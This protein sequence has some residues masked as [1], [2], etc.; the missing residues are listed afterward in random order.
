MVQNAKRLLYIISETILSIS[1]TR[2]LM[3]L[4]LLFLSMSTV[5]FALI[6]LGPGPLRIM[7]GKGAIRAI[8]KAMRHAIRPSLD[9]VERISRGQA[10]KK[11]GVGSR[12][13]PH[14]LNQAERKEWDLAKQR[15]YLMLRGTGWRKERK[16]SP[17]ANIYRNYCDAVGIPS[18]N[19]LRSLGISNDQSVQDQVVID[20]S[21][22]R[23][24]NVSESV[25][26]CRSKAH[27]F[28]SL[29]QVEDESDINA[30]GWNTEEIEAAMHERA[31][32]QIP[33]YSITATFSDRKASKA[34]AES[35]AEKLAVTAK[36]QRKS[37]LFKS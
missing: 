15:K 16:G 36:S 24:K 23:V 4:L 3:Q 31:I 5:A 13:V 11:R 30:L 10:A 33:V 21:P 20:F 1:R 9:D 25:E 19:V 12:G 35:V 6:S 26:F 2:K 37:A 7:T 29:V 32:W 27:Q 17:L 22:L 28:D 8:S 34:Y 14:R 18:I